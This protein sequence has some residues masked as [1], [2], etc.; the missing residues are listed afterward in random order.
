[1]SAWHASFPGLRI[2]GQRVDF[3]CGVPCMAWMAQTEPLYNKGYLNNY[4]L[5]MAPKNVNLHQDGE[6]SGSGGSLLTARAFFLC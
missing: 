2:K 4:K 6:L 1:M 5:G 3:Q